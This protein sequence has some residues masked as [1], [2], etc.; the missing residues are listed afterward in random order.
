LA[1][2]ENEIATAYA[3]R[4]TEDFA[5]PDDRCWDLEHATKHV[6]RWQ[7]V[8]EEQDREAGR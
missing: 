8:V 2:L 7:E 6:R 1:D 3:L 4:S 5:D